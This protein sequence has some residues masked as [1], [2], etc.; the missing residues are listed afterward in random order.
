MDGNAREDLTH[1]L[2]QIMK[3]FPRVRLRQTVPEGLKGREYD[4]LALLALNLDADTQTL[5]VTDVSNLLR[6]TPAGATHLLNSL[7]DLGCVQRSRSPDD[8]R[9]VLIALTDKGQEIADAIVANAQEK[10]SG[11]VD[12]LGEADTATL[13]RLMS[14][15]IAYLSA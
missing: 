6:I 11:L 8:R 3:R 5:T 9:V 7:V 14:K 10:L 12:Y 1:E 2:F 13:V 4:L 15:M